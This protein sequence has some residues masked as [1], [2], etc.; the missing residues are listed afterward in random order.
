MQD[1]NKFIEH[2]NDLLDIHLRDANLKRVNFMVPWHNANYEVHY[3]FK[4]KEEK[5]A[6]EMLAYTRVN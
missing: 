4:S 1:L 3:V 5:A 6:W 2:S